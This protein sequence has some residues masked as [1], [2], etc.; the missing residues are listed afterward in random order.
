MENNKRS[1]RPQRP[2]IISLKMDA[3]FFFEKAMQSL[4]RY[5]YD[6]ALKYF[7]RAVEYEPNNPIN[8]CNMAGIYSEI[9]NYEQ[10]NHILSKILNEID[11]SM[12]ECYFYMANNYAN[13]ES[14]EQ[15]EEALLRYLEKDPRGVFL[16][17]SEEMIE[18]LSYELDRPTPIKHI[19]SREVFF[20]HDKARSLMEEGKFTEAAAIL[21]RLTKKYPDFLAAHNNLALAHFYMGNM[22]QCTACIG[23][24]L[25]QEQGNVHALCNLAI[26]YKHQGNMTGL[27]QI[28]ELLRRMYPF[29]Q[30]HVF[31]LA[32]TLG[33]LGEHDSAYRHF[34]RL[35]NSGDFT[36]DPCLHHYY[37]VSSFRVGRWDQAER[38]WRKA[39]RLDP[40]SPVPA[41]YLEHIEELKE[42]QEPYPHLSYHYYLP[43]EDKFRDLGGDPE[44]ITEDLIRDPLI[45]SSFHWALYNGDEETKLQVIQAL[46][47]LADE[48]AEGVLR[49]FLKNDQEQDDMKKA[50]IYVL[51]AMGAKEPFHVVLEGKEVVIYATP[52]SQL[53]VW[54]QQWQDVM[55]IASSHMSK[56]YDLFQKHDMQTLW[57]EYLGKAY[58]SVPFI[59]KAEGWAAALEYLTAKMHSRPVTYKDLAGRYNVS[60][61]TIRKH[62]L[63]IDEMCGLK[64]K[65]ENIYSQFQEKSLR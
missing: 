22:E 19:K 48:D 13:M 44:G 34:Q 24:V 29:H 49:D 23:E 65:M 10:S 50:A 16:E 45:R 8:H 35:M 43:Y 28:L 64:E 27:E 51:K 7:Q 11:P 2:K 54:E 62:V 6:K 18:M 38:M 25:Q 41:F 12:T 42:M 32:M 63:T 55:E 60:V 26:V 53:P 52:S 59:Q 46:G 33:I 1:P 36:D 4:D 5:R 31:K 57:I 14:F 56:R 58:P 37:A 9:G 47:I 30:D 15:A 3:N 17:E 39:N 40:D 61:A 21:K 20:E